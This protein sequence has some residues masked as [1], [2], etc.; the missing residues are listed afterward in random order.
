MHRARAPIDELMALPHLAALQQQNKRHGNTFGGAASRFGESPVSRHRGGAPSFLAAAENSRLP[1]LGQHSSPHRDPSPR[2]KTQM[3]ALAHTYRQQPDTLRLPVAIRSP[4]AHAVQSPRSG[5]VQQ[6]QQQQQRQQQH[7]GPSGALRRYEGPGAVLKQQRQQ[8]PPPPPPLPPPEPSFTRT[9]RARTR[10]AAPEDPHDTDAPRETDATE[11]MYAAD[12]SERPGGGRRRPD[13]SDG[14]SRPMPKAGGTTKRTDPLG[15]IGFR[16][17]GPIAAGAFS[18]VV[19][20]TRRAGGGDGASPEEAAVKSFN[21]AKCAKG[22]EPPTPLSTRGSMSPSPLPLVTRGRY[23][24]AT[25]LKGA[26]KNEI[27]VLETL[28]PSKHDHVA[29]L[30]ELHETHQAT[31][32]VL[33]YCSGGSVHRHLRSLRHGQALS[34]AHGGV[35]VQQLSLALAHL[36]ELGIAHRD[37]KAENVL[38]TDTAKERIK[39]CDYG[40]AVVCGERKLR[41]VCGSPA[42]MPPRPRKMNTPAPSYHPWRLPSPAPSYHPWRLPSPATSYL[43]YRLPSPPVL[44]R[45]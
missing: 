16:T 14:S 26:L 4:R 8:H 33:E 5:A 6:Q 15:Q 1:Q 13:M 44:G 32:A 28:Q 9:R 35:L 31:H 25:W 30:I 18:T 20:A 21:R 41:S 23:A 19:R 7:P 10:L 43:P 40:F 37:V 24:K 42:Y 45:P 29:N 17:V 34:E 22:H 11:V 27:D 36:H 3:A 12:P 38:Y 2:M 39:L